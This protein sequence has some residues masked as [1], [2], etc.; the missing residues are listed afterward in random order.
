LLKSL[1]SIVLPQYFDDFNFC[2]KESGH[3][4][5]KYSTS[6]VVDDTE[7]IVSGETDIA[8]YYKMVCVYSWEDKNLDR[9]LTSPQEKGQIVSEVKAFAEE[10]KLKI[11]AKENFIFCG[12]ITSGLSWSFCK[13]R[14]SRGCARYVL[15]NPILIDVKKKRMSYDVD[16]ISLNI[17]TKILIETI[18]QVEHLIKEINHSSRMIH[19][20]ITE[21]DEDDELGKD[22]DYGF[23]EEEE[24]EEENL[25]R[26]LSQAKLNSGVSDKVGRDKN[27][28]K[29]QSKGKE[30]RTQSHRRP[31]MQ[32]YP[33]SYSLTADNLKIHNILTTSKTAFAS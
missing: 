2:R 18:M 26:Y 12:V 33:D 8:V 17:A 9:T 10:F 5:T 20:I 1:F 25:S 7:V 24:E 27:N 22:P 29:T 31:L 16:S 32:I 3:S 21:N 14:F 11:T 13:R 19:A 30:R 6:L 23:D 28:A 15:T 4:E